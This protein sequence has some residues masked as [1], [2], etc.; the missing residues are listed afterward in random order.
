M[1]QFLSIT[2]G[3]L[4]CLSSCIQ[5]AGNGLQ[6]SDSSDAFHF[7]FITDAHLE[8][9]GESLKYF[10]Q[11]IDIVNKINPDF[12]ISGGD[13][14]RD[15]NN[16]H[17]TYADSLYN[18]YLTEIQKFDM[19][20]YSTIGNHEITG[21]GPLSDVMPNNPM[22][23][24]GMFEKKIGKRF[25]SFEHKGWKFFMLD[26]LKVLEN[27]R[28]VV[29]HFDEEQIEWIKNELAKTDTLTPIAVCCHI[30]II[31]SIRKFEIGSM[32][33]TQ[34]FSA[35]DNSKEF[36][37]LFK[38]HKL[39]LVLQG[40]EHFLEVLYAKDIYFVTGT[41]VS[42]GWFITPPDFRG[43][44]SFHLSGDEIAWQFIANK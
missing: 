19:P 35:V 30:A 40:H 24:K 4:F 29:G 41:S 28:R 34:D 17:E 33:G 10:H 2:I 37:D 39:R 23:G 31:T 43:M 1:N 12:I 8:Y 20:V 15:A 25:S 44:V 13:F 36:F 5:K 18:L 9:Q 6:M 38:N 14:V 16:V 21:L 11:S 26:N 42:G 32:S 7:V 22:Y 3:I 27:E